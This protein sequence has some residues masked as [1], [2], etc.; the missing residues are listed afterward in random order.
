MRV[1]VNTVYIYHPNLLDRI[2]G[3][4]NLKSGDQV[5]VVNLPGCPK[6]NT[7]NHCYVADLNTGEFIGLV[8]CNSLHTKGEYIA[9]LKAEIAKIEQ[10][11][12]AYALSKRSV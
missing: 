2:D 11:K 10:K 3:R 7:M 6:A 5:R 9:Y 12:I 4:T 1:R 8:H